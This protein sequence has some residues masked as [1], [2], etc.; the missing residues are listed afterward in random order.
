MLSMNLGIGELSEKTALPDGTAIVYV[1]KRKM[2]DMKDFAA[3][4]TMMEMMCKQQKQNNASH[5]FYIYLNSQ[6]VLNLEK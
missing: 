3:Q 2:P 4:K 6:C 5:E 1:V